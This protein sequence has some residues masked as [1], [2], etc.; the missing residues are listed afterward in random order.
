MSL[1][2]LYHHLMKIRVSVMN[3]SRIYPRGTRIDSSNYSPV[4]AWAA[5]NQI[6]ALNYQ[7]GDL[8]YHINFGRFLEN[9]R[10]GYVLKPEYMINNQTIKR[11]PPLRITINVI[12]ACQLPKPGAQ[13]KGE[14]IDPYVV[15]YIHGP[16]ETLEQRTKTVIDNGF[17]PIWNEVFTFDVKEP[18]L[19]Y[20]TI[21]VNDEDVLSHEF[22]AFTSLPI[23]CMRSGFRSVRLYSIMGKTDQDFEYASLF[24]RVAMERL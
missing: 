4:P 17:N 22:I 11:D 21:Y 10:T 19:S 1:S 9:G 3:F 6:V 7:T 8:P 14:I 20:L 15:M 2:L 16:K 13:Q 23:S 18:D 5:G 24:L 12:S